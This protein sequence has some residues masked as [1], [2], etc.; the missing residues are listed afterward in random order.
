MVETEGVRPPLLGLA[1]G[2]AIVARNMVVADDQF[3]AGFIA[4]GF[5]DLDRRHNAVTGPATTVAHDIRRVVESPVVS[6]QID[7]CGYCY[8]V[9][10]GLLTE[11]RGYAGA[12]DRS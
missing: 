2:D 9:K 10:P 7:V 12:G 1:L 6:K 4:R 3:R 5:D 11:V 8:D